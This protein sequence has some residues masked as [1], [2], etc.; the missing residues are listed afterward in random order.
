[1]NRTRTITIR[2]CTPRGRCYRKVTLAQ[3]ESDSRTW[4][5]YAHAAF[6]FVNPLN[7]QVEEPDQWR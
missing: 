4:R 5:E 1:M 7:V 2:L 6:P 3:H